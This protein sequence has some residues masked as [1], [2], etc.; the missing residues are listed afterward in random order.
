MRVFKYFT[1]EEFACKCGCSGNGIQDDFIAFLD[2]LR[3][4]CGFAFHVNSGW[5]CKNHPDEVKKDKPGMHNTGWAAD[6]RISGSYQRYIIQKWA[7][8]LGFLG[9]GPAKG[10]V[11][12]DKREKESSWVY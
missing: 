9:I 12:V 4:M 8:A 10:F 11:H 5:R 3:E 2:E 6:I 1:R 7:Y